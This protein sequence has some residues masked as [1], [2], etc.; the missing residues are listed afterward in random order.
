ME[1]INNNNNLVH[2]FDE[3]EKKTSLISKILIFVV[4][5]VLG[6]GTGYGAA[7]YAKSKAP[8]SS[9]TTASTA[10][11]T[12]KTEGVNDAKNFKDTAT[13]ILKD[14]GI[15]GEGQFHLER[16]GGASQ[17][18]YLTSSAVDMTKYVGKNVQVWGQTFTSDKAGWLMDV[19]KISEL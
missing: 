8:A 4:V 15:D 16:P 11:E 2:S 1:N 10:V 7:Q 14:G 19:G 12:D 5:V 13:G 9:K 3:G 18:V 17:N 6:V